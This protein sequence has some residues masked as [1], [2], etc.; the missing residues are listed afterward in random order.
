MQGDVKAQRKKFMNLCVEGREVVEGFMYKNI[1]NVDIFWS[2]E[3]D[4]ERTKGCR[5]PK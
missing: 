2:V 5:G 3:G 4:A 1:P